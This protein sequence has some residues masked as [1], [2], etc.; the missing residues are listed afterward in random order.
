M[1]RPARSLWNTV[2]VRPGRRSIGVA[3]GGA[4]RRHA[5]VERPDTVESAD[6]VGTAAVAGSAMTVE[7]G[8]VTVEGTAMPVEPVAV[9]TPERMMTLTDGVVAIAMTLLVLDLNAAN[10]QGSS[11]GTLWRS[12]TH[13]GGR[14][15]AFFIAFWVIARFWLIH[16]R[17][18][19]RITRHEDSLAGR[20]FWFLFGIS[21]LPFTTRLLGETNDNP[22]PVALFSAN[23]LFVSVALT[24]LSLGAA[25][26]GA[27]EP[28]S[29]AGQEDER[30]AVMTRARTVTSAVLFVLPG[31]VVWVIPAGTAEL[32]FLLLFG[33]DLPGRLLL[34]RRGRGAAAGGGGGG[35]GGAVRDGRT[36]P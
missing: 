9:I 28:L 15:V 21:V 4:H 14:F 32:L 22:L 25:Q 3:R 31:A 27:A 20:N 6:T 19:R 23:L 34:R 10:Y 13:D 26:A 24:W 8:A 17:V 5:G 16:H 33:A 36:G 1:R 29:G 30:Q 35:A 2:T 7:G 11:A 12:L 18:F